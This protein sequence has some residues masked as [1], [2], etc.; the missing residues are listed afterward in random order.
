[1]M[2]M[3][4]MAWVLKNIM[5]GWGE[6]SC[7]IRFEV[8]NGSKIRFWHDLWFGDQTLNVAFPKFFKISCFKDASVADHLEFSS[9]S[10]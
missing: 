2:F 3:G 10:H 8:G 7:H 4:R 9:D 5:R 1:M 6:F